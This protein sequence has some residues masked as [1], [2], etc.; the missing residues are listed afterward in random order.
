MNFRTG[1]FSGQEDKGG[2][3]ALRVN[4]QGVSIELIF[5]FLNQV[6]ST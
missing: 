6:V 2:R 3:Y 1:V 5:Y 4:A